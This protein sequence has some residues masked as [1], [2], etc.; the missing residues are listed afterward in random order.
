MG[1]LLEMSRTEADRPSNYLNLKSENEKLLRE[2]DFSRYGQLGPIL[3]ANIVERITAAER[4]DRK[5][6][7]SKYV[8]P[9]E[10]ELGASI[11]GKLMLSQYDI[12]LGQLDQF[13]ARVDSA[14]LQ[15]GSLSSEDR[16]DRTDLIIFFT[17]LAVAAEKWQEA[18][19]LLSQTES[20]LADVTSEERKRQLTLIETL[21]AIK[22]VNL[23]VTTEYEKLAGQ[24]FSGYVCAEYLAITSVFNAIAGKAADD[25]I[26]QRMLPILLGG[27]ERISTGGIAGFEFFNNWGFMADEAGNYDLAISR[28]AEAL[29]YE[30]DHTWALLNW[31]KAAALSGDLAGAREKF[32]ESLAIGTIPAAIKNLLL[33]LDAL[34][35]MSGYSETFIKYHESIS[36]LDLEA[37]SYLELLA[38]RSACKQGKKSTATIL[39]PDEALVIEGKEYETKAFDY[40]SC[41]LGPAH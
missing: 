16:I 17:M 27:F 1:A 2:L 32:R 18:D 21:K 34:V 13:R 8:K 14:L 10:A 12:S 36:I 11:A 23:G 22:D 5:N 30:G 33:T 41:E 28:Y 37:R 19:K 4:T 40:R 3:K 38:M 9:I 35:D 31:G 20:K 6:A 26:R 25:P 15:N 24:G 39:R 7:Y 29:K